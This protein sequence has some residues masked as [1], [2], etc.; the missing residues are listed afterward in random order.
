MIK[1]ILL[2]L[3]LCAFPVFAQFQSPAI[4][5][6]RPGLGDVIN[7]SHSDS[8]DLIGAWVF[9]SNGG[10]TITDYAEQAPDGN[11]SNIDETSWTLDEPGEVLDFTLSNDFVD[12]GSSVYGHILGNATTVIAKIFVDAV[13]ANGWI[14]FGT[15]NGAGG[16]VFWQVENNTSVWIMGVKLSGM[17][18][19]NG[20]GE[21]LVNA[22]VST[23]T[24]LLFYQNGIL[25][26]SN[27]STGTAL[28]AGD[29]N[30]AIGDWIGSPGTSWALDGRV[31]YL[32]FYNR[33]LSAQE[34]ADIYENPYAMFKQDK[35]YVFGTAAAAPAAVERR[36]FIIT[37]D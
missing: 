19:I 12:L 35:I 9:V 31:E 13:D 29:K 25:E 14:V 24:G 21:W 32:Y 22:Y 15:Q 7:W 27:A 23:G 20:L 33:A 10:T 11:F 3:L 2:I 17:V 28:V 30:W 26:G 34:I 5:S 6:D 18:D 16:S 1:R 37:N 36:R 8:R 4:D